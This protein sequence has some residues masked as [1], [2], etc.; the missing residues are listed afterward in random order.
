MHL[1]TEAAQAVLRKAAQHKSGVPAFESLS[2]VRD[3]FGEEA[4][5]TQ[6]GVGI[7]GNWGK[8]DDNGLA[9]FV[10]RFNCDVERRIVGAALGALHPVNDTV[11][12]G[13]AGT[14]DSDAGVASEGL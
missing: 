5:V 12:F 10:G 7:E 4:I 2:N 8:E 14:A 6:V 1:V 13:R 11:A 9:Q 3:A